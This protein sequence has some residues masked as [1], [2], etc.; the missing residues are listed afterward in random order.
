M[1]IKPSHLPVWRAP[2]WLRGVVV[3]VIWGTVVVF[4]PPST[5]DSWWWL[6]I[7]ATFAASAILIAVFARPALLELTSSGFAL[8]KRGHRVPVDRQWEQCG[9]FRPREVVGRT[10]GTK[11]EVVYTAQWADQSRPRIRRPIPTEGEESVPSGFDDLDAVQ[12]AHLLN[13]YR[14]AQLERITQAEAAAAATARDLPAES[15]WWG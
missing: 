12:L 6:L 9:Q 7:L 10:G 13:R 14:A 8:T 5:F 11:H 4:C 3:G 2:S 15:W 1:L